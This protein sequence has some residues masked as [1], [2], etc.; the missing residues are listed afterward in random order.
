MESYISNVV[1]VNDGMTYLLHTHNQREWQRNTRYSVD[2]GNDD[3]NDED[4]KDEDE[5]KMSAFHNSTA[6]PQLRSAIGRIEFLSLFVSRRSFV[7]M[8]ICF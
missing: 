4:D 6:S 7:G 8:N 3:D 1:P 5:D 2:D